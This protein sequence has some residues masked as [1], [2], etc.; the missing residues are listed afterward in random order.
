MKIDLQAG[1]AR[2]EKKLD[3]IS[4]DHE[5]RL[6]E[7]EQ[8]VAKTKGAL[9]S[10]RAVSGVIGAVVGSAVTLLVRFFFP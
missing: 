3:D 8:W 10:A 9:G 1:I 5:K 6:R 2:V 7:L 4:S